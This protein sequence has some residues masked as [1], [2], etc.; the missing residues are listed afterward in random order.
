LRQWRPTVEAEWLPGDLP[1]VSLLHRCQEQD[2]D[3]LVTSTCSRI[4]AY[5]VGPRPKPDR[6]GWST[7][8]AQM[9]TIV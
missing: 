3:L 4:G 1:R 7:R 9:R 5:G 6:I 8:A 2:G